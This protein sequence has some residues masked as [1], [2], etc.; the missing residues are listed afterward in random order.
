MKDT[1]E[2][3]QVQPANMDQNLFLKHGLRAINYVGYGRLSNIPEDCIAHYAAFMPKLTSKTV[4]EDDILANV[5]IDISSDE[6]DYE[7]QNLKVL[8]LEYII[9]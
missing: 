2:R 6:S 9:N 1:K 5:E 4:P 3:R 8:R 7:G